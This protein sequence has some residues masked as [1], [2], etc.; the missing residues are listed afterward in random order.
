M[1]HIAFHLSEMRFCQVSPAYG[2][3]AVHK[4]WF[5]TNGTSHIVLSSGTNTKDNVVFRKFVSINPNGLKLFSSQKVLTLLLRCIVAVT[6]NIQYIL[7]PAINRRYIDIFVER[8]LEELRN[9]N[10][11]H[12]LLGIER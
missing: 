1:I 5:T 7:S 8:W 11:A 2:V 12:C 3:V 9:V 4:E 6:S 10:L